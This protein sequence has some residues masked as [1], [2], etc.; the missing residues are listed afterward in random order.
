M[1]V[2]EWAMFY[3][4]DIMGEVGFSTDFQSL[5]TGVEHEATKPLHDSMGLAYNVGTTMPWLLYIV[6]RIPGADGPMEKFVKLCSQPLEAKRKVR[7]PPRNLNDGL[8]RGRTY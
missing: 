1:D 5:R 3:S 6:L 4:F 2:T 8:P 7:P